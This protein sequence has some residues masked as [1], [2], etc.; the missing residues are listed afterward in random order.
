MGIVAIIMCV[1]FFADLRLAGCCH[2]GLDQVQIK[3]IA[4]I[5]LPK[6]ILVKR[7]LA[8]S[9]DRNRYN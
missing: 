4:L 1:V 3:V 9:F 7:V 6:V 8:V 2:A 5:I